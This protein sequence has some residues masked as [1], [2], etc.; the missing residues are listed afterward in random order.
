[1][2]DRDRLRRPG[3]KLAKYKGSSAYEV[4]S[5]REG[6]I[7]LLPS[8]DKLRDEANKFA[9]DL[10]GFDR[11]TARNG[12]WDAFRHAYASAILARDYGREF[13]FALGLGLEVFTFGPIKEIK[14]DLSNNIYGI[15]TGESA[16]VLEL[17][18]EEV[19][20]DLCDAVKEGYLI[21]LE[22]IKPKSG[23]KQEYKKSGTST[24]KS[25]PAQPTPQRIPRPGGE[26]ERISDPMK[27]ELGRPTPLPA[28]TR[29]DD[30]D[31]P[32]GRDWSYG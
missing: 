29:F 9:E 14:M 7:E 32:G 30:Y 18:K 10:C 20:K 15:K 16:R 13:S 23:E 26:V 25:K 22:P 4:S 19:A 24:I 28:D 27:R 2:L 3:T 21:V 31:R 1:M 11:K 8:L 12:D 17:T 6:T 5:S